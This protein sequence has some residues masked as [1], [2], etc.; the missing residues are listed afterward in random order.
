MSESKEV[1]KKVRELWVRLATAAAKTA[2]HAADF[3]DED[4]AE[5]WAKITE[6]W[7]KRAGARATQWKF[8]MPQ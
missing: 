1:A 2:V 7:L 3:A 8:R 6:R 5:R 4:T